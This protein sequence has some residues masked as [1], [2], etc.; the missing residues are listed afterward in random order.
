MFAA[1]EGVILREKQS[2]V[3]RGKRFV[4]GN[5]HL[6]KSVYILANA[7]V[8]F[9]LPEDVLG[10][11]K[12]SLGLLKRGLGLPKPVALRLK[13]KYGMDIFQCPCCKTGTMELMA[14]HY[15]AMRSDDG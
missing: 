14:V 5:R 10:L 9:V 15:F 7:E 4:S 3:D 11:P 6:I 1:G 13:E 12:R 8:L 2:S